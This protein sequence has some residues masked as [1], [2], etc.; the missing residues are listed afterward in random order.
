[1]PDPILDGPYSDQRSCRLL[2]LPLELRLHIW[3]YVCPRG[4]YFGL[5]MAMEGRKLQ[6]GL[7]LVRKRKHLLLMIPRPTVK[8]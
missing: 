4:Q 5:P 3:Q 2:K 8:S 7:I 1:M 6:N